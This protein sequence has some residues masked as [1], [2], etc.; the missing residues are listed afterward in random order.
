MSDYLSKAAAFA[1]NAA[2]LSKK[3][4]E[5]IVENAREFGL[6][7][8]SSGHYFDTSEEKMR[9]IKR[10]LDSRHDREKMD[11][12]KR[13]IANVASQNLEIRKLVYI[14]L[15]RYAEQEPDLALL[16]INTFQKD[17]TDQN[18][19][20]R[21]MA[22]RVMSG[23]RVPV[24]SPI[25][26]LAIKKCVT[27]LSAYV[28]KIAAHAIPKCYSLDP[29]QKDAL[30]DIITTLLK[31]N[32]SF[33]IG[34]V[35]M[36][37]NEVCPHR[38]DL[39]H[40]HFRKLCR[41]LIDADEW[42][43][44][45]IM[46]LLLRYARTQFLNPN[47]NGPRASK[48][49]KSKAF[50][51]DDE[52]SDKTDDSLENSFILDPD[53]E[54]LLRSCLPLLQSRNS[55]VVL[56]VAKIFYHLAPIEE[57]Y[58]LSKPL[59]RLL[60]S[61]REIQYVVLANIATMATQRPYLFEPHL[62]QFFVRSTD[63]VFIRNLKL[64]IMT[65]IATENN[66]TILLRELQEYVKSPNKEFA[67]SAI[68]A[69]GRCA[70]GM[71]DMAESCLNGLMKLLWSKN[72]AVVAES[73]VVIKRLLQL[74]PQDNADLI[75][76]LTKALDQITVPMARASI[77][78]LV[79]QYAQNLEKIAPDVLR[80]SA[81][82][83]INEDDI[84]KLQIINLGAKLYSLNP[85]NQVLN[86]LFQY[87]LN[88]ARYDLNY[89]IRDRARLLR[90]LILIN[91]QKEITSENE[92]IE[93]A[94]SSDSVKSSVL[95]ENLKQI[96]LC[97]KE[98]PSEE[99][100]SAGRDRFTIGSMALV[101]N[102][103]IPGY[104]P[105][106]DWPTEKPDVSARNNLDET[107]SRSQAVKGFGSDSFGGYAPPS[108]YD[109][110]LITNK[111]KEVYDLDHFY[112]SENSSDDNIHETSENEDEED[113]E[114]EDEEISEEEDDD[115]NESS[116]EEEESSEEETSEEETSEEEE[117]DDDDEQELLLEETRGKGKVREAPKSR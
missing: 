49:K 71:P 100:P 108:I 86:L 59:V 21:A 61:H 91:E 28:R 97:E 54:L 60:H 115:E 36:A 114:D 16:S 8:T 105:L 84:V 35:I 113:E 77:F 87:V 2:K 45:A 99:S 43:Q 90:G 103:S 75:I 41:M 18:Q 33:T 27:D 25:V 82:R 5:G 52:N 44:I 89:D 81:K 9:D 85:T 117:G 31:D 20:I 17:L 11:G 39:I 4:S 106:P 88:L 14:Y 83:F 51:S 30:V 12:L 38:F 32:S 92:E 78:W 13:L 98:A 34:S 63:S 109:K 53:H 96:L 24:I 73:V 76:Q 107:Y 19:L 23:I 67:T 62:Q 74:R 37:F 1:Q 111:R 94:Q 104:E 50:Y 40:P 29:T 22:L 42:G 68:Q 64:E 116:E 10:Q 55:A 46:G 26:L 93:N 72:D 70:I 57:A 102:H 69:I 101:L 95:K 48:K 7:A 56:S 80:N 65:L 112:D 110:P 6:E 66:I 58:K 15:L 47:P 79:G 3:V